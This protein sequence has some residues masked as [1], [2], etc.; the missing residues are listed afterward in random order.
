MR[1]IIIGAT[2]GFA[3]GW[4]PLANLD[5]TLLQNSIPYNGESLRAAIADGMARAGASVASV[6]GA[7]RQSRR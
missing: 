3:L 1:S 2:A 4:A 6:D 5:G 7:T